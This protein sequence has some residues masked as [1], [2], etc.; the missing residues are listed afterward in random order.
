MFNTG[1]KLNL[2]ACRNRVDFVV[3]SLAPVTGNRHRAGVAQLV[4]QL[5]CNH[6]VGGSNPFTGSITSIV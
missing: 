6:Q 4:E 5:I 1:I 2:T 3:F